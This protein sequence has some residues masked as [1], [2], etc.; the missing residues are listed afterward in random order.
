MLYLR[1][2]SMGHPTP[3][4]HQPPPQA[5][6]ETREERVARIKARISTMK[7]QARADFRASGHNEETVERL[8]EH[9][10]EM[11]HKEEGV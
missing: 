5:S 9:W 8:L 4:L 11:K 10:L 7:E 3:P 1:S 2:I 6:H